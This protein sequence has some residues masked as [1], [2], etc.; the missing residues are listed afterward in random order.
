MRPLFLR[1]AGAVIGN[2]ERDRQDDGSSF[3]QRQHFF[4]NPAPIRPEI[5]IR[6]VD[7]LDVRVGTIVAVDEIPD[8]QKLMLLTV[9]FGDHR[10]SIVA[11]IKKERENPQEIVGLQA[12]FVLNM[13]P[14]KLAGV[15]SE[16]MM[17]DIGYADKINPVLATPEKPVPNGSRAG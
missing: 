11:G 14:Q 2:N 8:S 12:L 16:G 15:T 4:M 6:D 7:K 9:D 10:R 17:F 13:A 3:L 5:T 1:H